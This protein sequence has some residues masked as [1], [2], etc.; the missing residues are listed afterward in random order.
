MREV[1]PPGGR[2]ESGAPP[3]GERIMGGAPPWGSAVWSCDEMDHDSLCTECSGSI[4]NQ[5][6][7]RTHTHT[8]MG[9]D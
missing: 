9:R 6:E 5:G 3:A 7:E 1:E 4:E 2:G 8:Q